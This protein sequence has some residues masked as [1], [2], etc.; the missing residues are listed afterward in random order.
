MT[1]HLKKIYTVFLTTTVAMDPYI[2]YNGINHSRSKVI[3]KQPG[4]SPFLTIVTYL[5]LLQQILS[6]EIWNYG[7]YTSVVTDLTSIAMDN[8]D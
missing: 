5:Y 1:E 6:Q 4:N 7:Q 2:Y 3:R 8:L